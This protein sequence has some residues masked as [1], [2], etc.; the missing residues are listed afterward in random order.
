MIPFRRGWSPGGSVSLTWSA[1]HRRLDGQCMLRTESPWR[2]SLN[3]LNSDAGSENSAPDHNDSCSSLSKCCCNLVGRK[4][5]G[6]TVI[7][8]ADS[9]TTLREVSNKPNG[10]F[11][12]RSNSRE[13]TGPRL[14]Y[15]PGYSMC[16]VSFGCIE[17]T[18]LSVSANGSRMEQPEAGRKR[19]VFLTRDSMAKLSPT[20]ARLG[21]LRSID[22]F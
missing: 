11:E 12:L 15:F 5:D 9:I 18:G 19:D 7:R 3:N 21:R 20:K 13:T 1:L 2:N 16:A 14:P 10:H 22:I 8:D 6:R 4:G 17:G